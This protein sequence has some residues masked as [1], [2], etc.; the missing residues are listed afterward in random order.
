MDCHI[1]VE[2]Q[3]TNGYVATVMGWP[4]CSGTGATKDEALN[5]VHDVMVN[6]LKQ[7]EIV[8]FQVEEPNAVIETDPWEQMIGRFADDSQWEDFQAELTCI[9]AGANRD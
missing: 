7:A 4:D 6:R 5:K 9:R 8:H 1:L 3:P 2:K